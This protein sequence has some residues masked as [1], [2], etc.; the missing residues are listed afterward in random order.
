MEDGPS[1]RPE[2]TNHGRPLKVIS[3][4]EACAK[5]PS[6]SMAASE[7]D[8]SMVTTGAVLPQHSVFRRGHEGHRRPVVAGHSL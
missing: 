6:K 4:A 5:T 1:I 2:L 3:R 7:S 8:R